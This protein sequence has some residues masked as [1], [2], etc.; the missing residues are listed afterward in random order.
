MQIV[1]LDHILHHLNLKIYNHC[2][3]CSYVRFR[4]YF[5]TLKFEKKYF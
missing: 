2:I 1:N 5:T 3:I 4:A